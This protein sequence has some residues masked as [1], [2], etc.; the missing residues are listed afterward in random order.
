MQLFLWGVGG[1][2]PIAP[3]RKDGW[4]VRHRARLGRFGYFDLSIGGLT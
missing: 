3:Q 4:L 1:R 2:S